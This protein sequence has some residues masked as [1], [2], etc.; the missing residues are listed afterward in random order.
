MFHW[1]LSRKQKLLRNIVVML[2]ALGSLWWM[3]GFPALTINGLQRRAE[4]A[5]LLDEKGEILYSESWLDGG[6]ILSWQRDRLMS[7]NWERTLL[8]YRFGGAKLFD[9]NVQHIL[10]YSREDVKAE[11]K[12]YWYPKLELWGLV[13]EPA[14][15]VLEWTVTAKDGAVMTWTMPGVRKDDHCLAFVFARNYETAADGSEAETEE[16]FLLGD[17]VRENSLAQI[18]FYNEVGVLTGIHRFEHVVG[19]GYNTSIRGEEP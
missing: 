8:G 5:Y 11:G 15:A 12:T 2:A 14:A 6:R 4:Q 19:Y 10:F 3:L 7:T 18:S 16:R 17:Y 13:E 1:K 9:P